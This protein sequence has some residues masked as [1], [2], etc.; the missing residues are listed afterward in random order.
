MAIDNILRG[1]GL[2]LEA[3]VSVD[4]TSPLLSPYG[5]MGTAVPAYGNRVV[6][7]IVENVVV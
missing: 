2:R 6:R 5:I 7:M 1:D 4:W 3:A